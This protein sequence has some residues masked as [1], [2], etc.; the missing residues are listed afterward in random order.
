MDHIAQ[1]SEAGAEALERAAEYTDQAA[2]LE[3]NS[4]D[5]HRLLARIRQHQGNHAE[6]L[7]HSKRALEL[8]PNDGD[9]LANHAL[10]LLY[11]GQSA[12]ARPWAEEAMRRNPQF[13]GWYATVLAAV[14]YL[15]GRYR[16]AVAVLSRI[17]KPAIYDHRVLA[18]SYGQL[19]E[20]EKA[21]AHVEKILKIAPDYSIAAFASSQPYQ[22]K[23]DLEHFLDGL[24]KAGLP[25]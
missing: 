11:A 25:E 1:W 4:Y 18:A 22:R 6:A 24:R 15:A 7:A 9:L 10:L 20:A 13:P 21:R 14:H 19:G 8:N 16:E 3:G 12:E 5:V 17:D 2:A 23:A